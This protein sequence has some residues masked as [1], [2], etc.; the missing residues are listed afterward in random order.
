MSSIF[1]QALAHSMLAFHLFSVYRPPCKKWGV[2]VE[3]VRKEQPS[4][5]LGQ[6]QDW[7]DLKPRLQS[8]SQDSLSYRETSLKDA[9]EEK[10]LIGCVVGVSYSIVHAS[11]NYPNPK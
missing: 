9:K 4:P 7:R 10:G 6:R 5:K 2:F 11:L 3:G 8:S 1:A